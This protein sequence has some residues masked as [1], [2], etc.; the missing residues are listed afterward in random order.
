MKYV[1]ISTPQGAVYVNLN[2]KRVYEFPRCFPKLVSWENALSLVSAIVLFAAPLVYYYTQNIILVFVLLFCVSCALYI[3]LHFGWK[4]QERFYDFF[5]DAEF[6]Q[7]PGFDVH[8]LF[9]RQVFKNIALAMCEILFIGFVGVVSYL[10][11]KQDQ[12]IRY[13]TLCGVLCTGPLLLFFLMAIR[14]IGTIIDYLWYRGVVSQRFS[15]I[16][17]IPAIAAL[18]LAAALYL[19]V[20]VMIGETRMCYK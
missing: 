13:I 11:I 20:G 16:R 1:R 4:A 12:D 9:V 2:T 5:V 6:T 15:W 14:P 7:K 3:V 18:I 10:M 19:V 8:G 17:N